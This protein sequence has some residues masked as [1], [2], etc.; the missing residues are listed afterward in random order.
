MAPATP[1]DTAS[2]EVA[3]PLFTYQFPKREF[4]DGPISAV[5][6]PLEVLARVKVS[7]TLEYQS[8]QVP[9]TLVYA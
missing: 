2:P 9:P 3:A 5:P 8:F 1:A 7:L 4:H 6:K